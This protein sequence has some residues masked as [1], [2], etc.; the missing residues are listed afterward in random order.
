MLVR[1]FRSLF[2]CRSTDSYSVEPK[3]NNESK[4][5]EDE[6]PSIPEVTSEDTSEDTPGDTAPTEVGPMKRAPL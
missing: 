6:E 5:S 3:K 1:F 4:P 2:S